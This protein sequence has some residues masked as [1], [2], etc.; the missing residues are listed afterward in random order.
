MPSP[1]QNRSTRLWLTIGLGII[2]FVS[3]VPIIWGFLIS[4]KR[5]VDAFAYPPKLIFTPTFQF[6]R[7]IWLEQDFGAY[8]I[9]SLVIS[10]AV[11]LIS[12]PIGTMAAFALSRIKTRAARSALV[13]LLVARMFPHMLLVVPFFVFAKTLGLYDTYIALILPIVAINQPFTIWMMR[14]FFADVPMELDE[15]ARIDGCTNW[16]IFTR[17]MLPVV[18]PGLAV[19]ALFSLLLSYNEFLIPLVLAGAEHK[20]LSVAITEFGAEDITYWSLSAAGALGITLPIVAVMIFAQ[21]HMIR[22]MTF[23]AVKG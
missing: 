15:A 3:L 10:L 22:G 23:G 9:N 6:H 16:Q 13:A 12:V 5:P 7:E 11:V 14:S 21:R 19:T 17:V 18:K 8:L 4:I 20:P 2:T 1:N